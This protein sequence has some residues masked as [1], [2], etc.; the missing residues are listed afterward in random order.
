[1]EKESKLEVF[2]ELLPSELGEFRGRGGKKIVR[3]RGDGE[4]GH[5]NYLSKAHVNSEIEAESTGLTWFFT[6]SYIHHIHTHTYM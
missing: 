6:R 5:L 2:I 4:Q 1:M 3:A